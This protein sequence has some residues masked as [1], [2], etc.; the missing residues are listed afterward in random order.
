MTTSASSNPAFV[1]PR[2]NS[3]NFAILEGLTYDTNSHKEKPI[4]EITIDQ[5]STHLSFKILSSDLIAKTSSIESSRD[6]STSPSIL[7][8][9]GLVVKFFALL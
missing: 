8:F 5:P 1:S 4:H 7:T 6:F 9:Q 3:T 2:L